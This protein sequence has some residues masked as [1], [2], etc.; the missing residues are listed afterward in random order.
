MATKASPQLFGSAW[1]SKLV[2][3]QYKGKTVQKDEYQNNVDSFIKEPTPSI[4]SKIIKAS[5]YILDLSIGLSWLGF[6]QAKPLLKHHF[7]LLQTEYGFSYTIEKVPD[8]ILLQSCRTPEDT[9]V[10]P[11]IIRQRNG[12]EREMGESLQRVIED[13]NPEI[14]VTILDILRWINKDDAE[15]LREAYDVAK[16][17]CQDFA[18]NAWKKVSNEDYPNPAKFENK[19]GKTDIM[20]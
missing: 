15:E 8:C 5:A 9:D 11:I 19:T 3:A 4:N 16:S 17:N 1:Q 20:I 6:G 14:H 12:E 10:A 2:H 13:P 18:R 7:L